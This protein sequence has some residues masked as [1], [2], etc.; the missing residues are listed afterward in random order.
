MILGEK[1]RI[2]REWLVECESMSIPTNVFGYEVLG[3]MSNGADFAVRRQDRAGRVEP[4]MMRIRG[5][6]RKVGLDSGELT[7]IDLNT[8]DMVIVRGGQY[9][10]AEFGSGDG[11]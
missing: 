11:V 6:W 8:T 5:D 9:L 2:L 1:N 3:L 4:W 7:W 10:V